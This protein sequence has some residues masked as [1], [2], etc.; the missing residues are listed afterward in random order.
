M[1]TGD[2]TYGYCTE[3]GGSQQ[4]QLCKDFDYDEF[5]NYLNDLGDSWCQRWVKSS[6]SMSIPKIQDWLCRKVSR[7]GS[8]VRSRW[9]YAQPARST[10]VEKEERSAKPAQKR[11]CDYCC[12]WLVMVWAEIFKA[13]GVDYIISGQTMNPINK[14]TSWLWASQCS[15]II[16]LPNNK[17]IFMAAQSAEVI[18]QP[19]A[20]I[21]T[22]DPSR[23]DQSPSFW[24][25]QDYR[26]KP[27]ACICMAE[28]VSG[29]VTTARFVIR[30]LMAWKFMR[31]TTSVW[32]MARLLFLIHAAALKET[33]NQD[34]QWRQRDCLYL[35]QWRRQRKV[36]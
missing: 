18:K 27:R 17:N 16:I 33:F 24:W 1:A 2:I 9:Q 21:E 10:Q 26:G 14:K 32:W 31:V 35:Y 20:V 23:F 12:E 5:R 7:Y 19:A 22:H 8:L 34:A 13:Q 15:C 25:Q 30:R 28:V 11:I 29:S 36:G 4:I 3:I 6:K